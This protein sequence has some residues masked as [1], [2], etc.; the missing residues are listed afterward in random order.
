MTESGR[1]GAPHP[2]LSRA[3]A[4]LPAADVAPDAPVP[5]LLGRTVFDLLRALPTLQG[6]VRVLPPES[7]S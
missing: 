7:W 4:L 2:Q 1:T 3:F 5:G 6:A